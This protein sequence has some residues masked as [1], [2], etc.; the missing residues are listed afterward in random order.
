MKVPNSPRRAGPILPR[1]PDQPCSSR[2]DDGFTGQ[3]GCTQHALRETTGSLLSAQ[4]SCSLR[5]PCEASPVTPA[6]PLGCPGGS[7]WLSTAGEPDAVECSRGRA[8]GSNF[9]TDYGPQ[10][11]AAFDTVMPREARSRGLDRSPGD[12]CSQHTW[13][14]CPG[15]FPLLL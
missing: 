9:H 11:Q 3:G 4:G 13:S 8:Q 6:L 15:L 5:H 1:A 7:S 2:Y 10:N 12:T 14:G